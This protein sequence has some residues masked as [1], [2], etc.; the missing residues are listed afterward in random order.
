[1]TAETISPNPLGLKGRP[2]QIAA[3][4]EG[5]TDRWREILG[6]FGSVSIGRTRAASAGHEGAIRSLEATMAEIDVVLAETAAETG[7][8]VE[9]HVLARAAREA[10]P[11]IPKVLEIVASGIVE[12]LKTALARLEEEYDGDPTGILFG[13]PEEARA[14]RALMDQSDAEHFLRVF[15]GRTGED[16]LAERAAGF[17]LPVEAFAKRAAHK[18]WDD[19][20]VPELFEWRDIWTEAAYL[21]AEALAARRTPPLASFMRGEDPDEAAEVV[22][23]LEP[24][25]M[26]LAAAS[27]VRP[28]GYAEK[29]EGT[30]RELENLRRRARRQLDAD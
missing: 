20:T 9:S 18:D 23:A 3:F 6:P 12:V 22:A 1:M 26:L 29:E 15:G 19:A 27:A 17:E 25:E 24:E 11:L 5:L 13:S 4:A 10:S 16:A 21:V 28:R 8:E 30:I 2:E 7:V 14:W